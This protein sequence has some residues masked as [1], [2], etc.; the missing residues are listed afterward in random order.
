MT[1][2]YDKYDKYRKKRKTWTR[3]PQTQV[4][5]SRKKEKDRKK[6]RKKMRIDKDGNPI[7]TSDDE[8]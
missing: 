5:K 7:S 6:C 2:S 3:D 1:R 4:H 8:M